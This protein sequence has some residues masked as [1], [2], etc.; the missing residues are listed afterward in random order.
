MNEALVQNAQHDVDGTQCGDQQNRLIRFGIL[1]GLRC[2]LK[3]GVN[4]IGNAEPTTRLLNVLKRWIERSPGSQVERERDGREK[5]LV[6]H[7]ECCTGVLVVRE[8]A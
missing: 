3:C 5:S 8:R 2:A 7:G 4:T 6:I 1:K